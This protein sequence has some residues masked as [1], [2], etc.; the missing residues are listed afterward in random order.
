MH[1]YT[2][3]TCIYAYQLQL[4][5]TEQ[6]PKTEIEL[7]IC[8]YVCMCIVYLRMY[9]WKYLSVYLCIR[10]YGCGCLCVQMGVGECI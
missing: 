4:Y 6:Q 10:T 8:I 3:Y 7:N 1:V 5:H 9:V 2:V